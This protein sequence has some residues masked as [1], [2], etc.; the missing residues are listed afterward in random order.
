MKKKEREREKK[1]KEKRKWNIDG[2]KGRNEAESLLLN[3]KTGTLLSKSHLRG[4]WNDFENNKAITRIMYL[5]IFAVG[6]LR[7]FFL[8]LFFSPPFLSFLP[9]SFLCRFS[10]IFNNIRIPFPTSTFIYTNVD[11]PSADRISEF[12][13]EH[14]CF[15]FALPSD[16]TTL[17]SK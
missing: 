3:D 11:V 5:Y 16:K 2:K 17:S 12:L 15:L 4:I 9:F 13:F 10:S 7:I 1:E 8:F 6:Y 14:A